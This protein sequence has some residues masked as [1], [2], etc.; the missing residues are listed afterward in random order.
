[1]ERP[2]EDASGDGGAT[3]SGDDDSASDGE[4]GGKGDAETGADRSRP[5]RSAIAKA[6]AAALDIINSALPVLGLIPNFT[7]AA[8][9]CGAQ[10]RSVVLMGRARTGLRHADM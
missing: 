6:K 7:N 10:C 5:G 2:E 4:D 3:S 8:A 1:M 9:Y